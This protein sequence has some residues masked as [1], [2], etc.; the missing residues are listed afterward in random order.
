[1]VELVASRWLSCCLSWPSSLFQCAG[2]ISWIVRLGQGALGEACRNDRLLA[3]GLC[4]ETRVFVVLIVSLVFWVCGG[5]LET[6][7]GDGFY[8]TLKEHASVYGLAATQ[9]LL[10]YRCVFSV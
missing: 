3:L 8:M 6:P 4:S 7:S 10:V 5:H 1:M 9:V 2:L